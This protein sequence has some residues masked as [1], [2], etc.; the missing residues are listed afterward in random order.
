MGRL[1]MNLYLYTMKERYKAAGKALKSRI[2]DEFCATS[3]Y[4]RKSAIRALNCPIKVRTRKTQGRGRKAIYHCQDVLEALKTIWFATDQICGQRLKE[5]LGLWLPYYEAHH[6]TLSAEAKT[7][8]ISMSSATI[9]RLLKPLRS[10]S[11]RGIS[12]TRPGSLLKTRIPIN[13][14]Q[15]DNSVP[16]FVEADTVAHCGNSIAGDFVWSL[17]LVDI[18]TTWVEN[19]RRLHHRPSHSRLSFNAAQRQP[20]YLPFF[21]TYTN[22]YK[23]KFLLHRG[24]FHSNICL[25]QRLPLH[26]LEIRWNSPY[27]TNFS[28][29]FHRDPWINH[30]SHNEIGDLSV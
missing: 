11:K 28:L 19:H 6:G 10:Q 27:L 7:Q 9:D 8:L 18:A 30:M 15:W 25:S 23:P 5:T 16:G 3:G 26:R 24:R 1:T 20:A 2:L 14:D 4:N 12:G 29:H 22:L 17:T 13:K 21:K